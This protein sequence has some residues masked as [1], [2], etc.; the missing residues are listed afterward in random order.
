MQ[1]SRQAQHAAI[2]AAP[3]SPPQ[4]S[5]HTGQM[6]APGQVPQRPAGNTE[7]AFGTNKVNP[8]APEPS[9]GGRQGEK[10]N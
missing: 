8:A 4:Q 6:T 2:P 9:E 5:N 3:L 10:K 1:L 7:L